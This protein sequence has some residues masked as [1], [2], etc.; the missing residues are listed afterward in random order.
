MIASEVHDVSI[1]VHDFEVNPVH[2]S[3]G[4]VHE[5]IASIRVVEKHLRVVGLHGDLLNDH[6][7]VKV[8]NDVEVCEARAGY[9]QVSNGV[10][11]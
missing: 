4:H 1:R 2:R 3:L 8:R 6:V 11:I 10:Q 5:I 7:V 9:I